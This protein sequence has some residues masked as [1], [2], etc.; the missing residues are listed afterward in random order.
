MRLGQRPEHALV[1]EAGEE[2]RATGIAKATQQNG[3]GGKAWILLAT[4][5]AVAAG[6]EKLLR[7][8]IDNGANFSP[9]LSP[10]KT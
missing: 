4:C 6:I 8:R 1:A 2:R 5:V 10:R 7:G 9:S 3:K